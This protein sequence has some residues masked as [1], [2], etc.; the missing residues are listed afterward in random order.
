MSDPYF[1]APAC[2]I[3]FDG[4]DETLDWSGCP[5]VR[6]SDTASGLPPREETQVQCCWSPERFYVRFVCRDTYAVSKFENRDDPLYEQDVVELFIDE[7]GD[8]RKYLELEVSP[9]NVVFDAWIEHDGRERVTGLDKE[10]N[11]EGL[12]TGVRLIEP[13]CREYLI[14]IPAAHFEAPLAPGVQWR[15]NFYRIDEDESGMREYQAW[16]PTGKINF[17]M[18]SRFGTVVLT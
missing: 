17:H 5:I 9:R 7:E 14:S 3:R 8:G 11:L 1:C 4:S 10:W 15:A 16:R 2:F 6:L 12:R 18:P 13:D